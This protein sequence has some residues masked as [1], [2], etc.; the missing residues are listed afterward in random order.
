VMAQNLLNGGQVDLGAPIVRQYLEYKLGHIISKLEIPCPPDYA[1]RGDRRTLSTY[2]DAIVEAID[3]YQAAGRCVLTV[4]QVVDIKNT[5]VPS[6]VSNFVSHYETGTG[7]PFGAYALLGVLQS[8]DALADCFAWT[9]LTQ[10]PP[11][12]KF[13][14]RLD[15]Q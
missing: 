13:Y 9:D 7:T 12:K 15:R 2:L 4:Q 14:K 6:I 3:L 1:T 5:L 11:T 10:N 8:I